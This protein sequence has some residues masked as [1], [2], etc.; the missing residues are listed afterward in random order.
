[1]ERT[2]L[3]QFLSVKWWLKTWEVPKTKSQAPNYKCTWGGRETEDRGSKA[4]AWAPWG[5]IHKACHNP[6]ERQRPVGQVCRSAQPQEGQI[7]LAQW[8]ACTQWVEQFLVPLGSLSSKQG[9]HC[10][11]SLQSLYSDLNR[12][13]WSEKLEEWNPVLVQ[14]WQDEPGGLSCMDDFINPPDQ[15]S[16]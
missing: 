1:M 5:K 8:A 14:S 11:Q 2:L 4:A 3:S 15:N 7:S 16:W 13:H 12:D 9:G 6:Q 10:S